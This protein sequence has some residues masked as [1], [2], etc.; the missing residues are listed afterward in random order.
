MHW[1]DQLNTGGIGRFDAGFVSAFDRLYAQRLRRF[2]IALEQVR[3]SVE[4]ILNDDEQFSTSQRLRIRVE[5]GRIKQRDRLLAKAALP[6]YEQRIFAPTDVFS[7]ITDIAG[8]RITCNTVD[9]I[10]AVVTAIKKSTTLDEPS[11]VE[12]ERC[13]EDYIR[14]PKPS[15]YRAVHLLVATRVPSGGD[16]EELGCEIQIRTLLQHA[17]GELTHEDTFKPEFEVPQLVAKLSTRLATTLAVLDEIA[18]DLRDELERFAAA[19]A[20]AN[21]VPE[22]GTDPISVTTLPLANLFETVF[23]RNLILSERSRHKVEAA[24]T[25]YRGNDADLTAALTAVRQVWREFS[26]TR[27]VPISDGDLL[28]IA[29]RTGGNVELIKQRLELITQHLLQAIERRQ[30]FLDD[31]P[32]GQEL[33]GSVTQ[34]NRTFALV[35]LPGGATGIL[36]NRNLTWLPKGAS[37]N[38]FLLP[39][40][41][42]RAIVVNRDPEGE[43]LEIT[44][45]DP[46]SEKQRS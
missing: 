10:D 22:G 11:W 9:D 36:S 6:K 5:H 19:S 37:L 24:S 30:R 12:P 27:P 17:W 1:S 38:R 43:R 4:A 40:D 39:G 42:V 14:D 41:T 44:V 45:I 35:R 16:F 20:T 2:E 7:Q 3:H 32:V 18:Q 23:G 46:L 25:E 28:N 33:L 21:E 8:M 26:K 34:V 31:Y 15:G 29:L 13:K